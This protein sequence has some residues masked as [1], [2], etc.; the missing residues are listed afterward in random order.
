MIM[1]HCD[2]SEYPAEKGCL[3]AA[4]DRAHAPLRRESLRKLLGAKPELPR[5]AML[6]GASSAPRTATVAIAP[7]LWK[8][9]KR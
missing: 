1:I 8:V 6:T 2:A 4:A 3:R 9:V 5:N 7:L